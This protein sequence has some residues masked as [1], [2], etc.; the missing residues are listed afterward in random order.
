MWA[1]QSADVPEFAS[2][3]T[4]RKIFSSSPGRA[5]LLIHNGAPGVHSRMPLKWRVNFA[6]RISHRR[7][8]AQ[9]YKSL[10]RARSV[11]ILA[12]AVAKRSSI[13]PS[14]SRSVRTKIV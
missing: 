14:L 12:D 8:K 2:E 1:Y 3:L 13:S 4:S 11:C 5:C 6:G 7:T 9:I 10:I